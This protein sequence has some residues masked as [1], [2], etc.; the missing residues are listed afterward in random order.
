MKTP[1]RR[2][3]EKTTPE[4]PVPGCGL[5]PSR[6]GLYWVRDAVAGLMLAVC[7]GD[8]PFL[9]VRLC[10]PWDGK[11]P[12]GLTPKGIAALTWLGEIERPVE[13]SA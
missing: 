12:V 11:F 1:R 8:A 7:D 10:D 6:E 2:D 5:P 9:R 4:L 3:A 13:R